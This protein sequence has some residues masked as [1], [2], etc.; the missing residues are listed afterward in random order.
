MQKETLAV[1]MKNN[2]GFERMEKMFAAFAK[3]SPSPHPKQEP[4][5]QRDTWT[6]THCKA[7]KCFATREKCYKCGEPRVPSPPG[8]GAKAAAVKPAAKQ[9]AAAA[10]PMEVEVIEEDTLEDMIAEVEDSL[11]FLRGKER[12]G[13]SRRSWTWK[14]S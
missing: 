2:R 13:P 5:S 9:A 4:K 7:E 10:E 8:L 6:C 3:G 11:K 14:Q 12:C 1:L